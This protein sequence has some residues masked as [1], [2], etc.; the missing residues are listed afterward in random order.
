MSTQLEDQ[1]MVIAGERVVAAGGEWLETVDPATG[2]MLAR[3]PRGGAEDIDRA[4]AAAR[5]AQRP[6]ADRPPA[7]RGAL[8][9][10]VSRRL[11]AERH[12]FA[13]MESLDTGKPLR[14]ALA[15]VDVAARYFSFYGGLAD[16]LRGTS[17][18][19]GADFID[20]TVREPRGVSAQIVPW[21][22]PL[23]IGSRGI[24]P[25]LATGNAVVVK[26]AEEA[27]L[28]LL[29]LG[30]LLVE[31][32][33][34]G[35][36]VNVVSGLGEEAGAALAAHPGIDQ[37]TFTGSVSTGV[38]V[39]QAAARNIVPVTLELGG[40]CPNVVFDDADVDA[41]L[42]VLLNAIIQNAGQTCSAATRLI[43][44][45]QIHREVA[46][47]LSALM[48]AVGMGPGIEDPHMGPL[49]SDQQRQKVAEFVD[50]A[51]GGGACLLAGGDTRQTPGGGFFYPATLL[52]GVA[53]DSAV[54]RQEIFGPVLTVLPFSTE[55]EAVE[56][57]NGTE[58]GLVS[59][60]WTRDL[61]R[62]HRVSA[63][64]RTG[65]VFVNGYGAAGGVE[66]PFGGYGKSGFGREK[67]IEGV[68]SYLQT[69]NVC[70]RVASRPRD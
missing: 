32:G 58:F 63:A 67:G 9:L 15:D 16:K 41:A 29:R 10:Q 13:R 11:A 36:V 26:P 39:A 20:Y 21:N 59:G 27:P 68:E 66:L 28:T 30:E 61:S 65:Q 5:A 44:S 54:A 8:L 24:A 12:E 37:L 25:A 42:P 50:Q 69:K 38:L 55:S 64:L 57:A 14:Q 7:E 35:G 31:E 52:D 51:V 56:L 18:P 45:R 6:W 62:A 17:I 40:K 33:L 53:P 2:S 3:V 22:Y 60:I 47:R 49:I 4:I 19:M 1:A 43:V 34:P 70:I 48:A 46:E 23:Q